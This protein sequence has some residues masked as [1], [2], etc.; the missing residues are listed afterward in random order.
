MNFYLFNHCF[1]L[2]LFNEDFIIHY[3]HCVYFYCLNEDFFTRYDHCAY[4]YYLNEDF[5]IFYDHCVYF[6][7]LI[8]ILLLNTI[9]YSTYDLR[10]IT[11]YLKFDF[12]QQ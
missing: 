8:K 1:L 2:S 12:L 9:V 11:F 5:F 6:H 10:E 3:N 4:F 7:C